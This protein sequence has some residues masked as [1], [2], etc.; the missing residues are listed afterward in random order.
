MKYVIEIK[1]IERKRIVLVT[2]CVFILTSLVAFLTEEY[3]R[4]LVRAILIFF[5]ENKIQF[6]GKN[7]HLFA[8]LGFVLAFGIFASSMFLILRFTDKG[9]RVKR[10]LLTVM[11]F[12]MATILI[13]ALDAIRLVTECTACRDG[14]RKLT[15]NQPSYDSYFIV[16][17]IIA[18][19]YI[20]V[21]LFLDR[22]KG[23]TF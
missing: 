3:Y 7:F 8:S 21:L 19:I 10:L 23:K 6:I 4:Q 5:S 14:I 1:P 17:L 11:A 13:T 18:V 15:F 20:L 16:S 9:R 2:M 22:R 12:F